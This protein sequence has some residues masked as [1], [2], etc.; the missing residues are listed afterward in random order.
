MEYYKE[1]IDINTINIES[2]EKEKLQ[3]DSLIGN[4][5]NA[6]KQIVIKKDCNVKDPYKYALNIEYEFRCFHGFGLGY[7]KANDIRDRYKK[8]EEELKNEYDLEKYKNAFN[9]INID[10]LDSEGKKIINEYE[11]RMNRIKM[12]SAIEVHNI[13]I[14]YY[15]KIEEE[16]DFLYRRAIEEQKN[17]KFDRIKSILTNPIILIGVFINVFLVCLLWIEYGAWL[18]SQAGWSVVFDHRKDD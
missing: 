3:D 18:G 7:K 11:E 17:M 15:K 10:E 4:F 2:I 9:E 8:E 12:M 16:F 1:K 13:L 5:T 14:E 6:I